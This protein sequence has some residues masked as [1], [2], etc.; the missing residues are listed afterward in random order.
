MLVGISIFPIVWRC[1]GAAEHTSTNMLTLGTI[2]Q[3]PQAK[4][5]V[6]ENA[7]MIVWMGP[8]TPYILQRTEFLLQL[9]PPVL[10]SME[11]SQL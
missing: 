2:W 9:E 7:H 8:A 5:G 1:S 3:L 4:G 6:C 10:W 11:Y